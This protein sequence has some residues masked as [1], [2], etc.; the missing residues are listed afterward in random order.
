MYLFKI[1]TKFK[2]ATLRPPKAQAAPVYFVAVTKA[3]AER[4]AS[5]HLAAHLEVRG[6]TKLGAQLANGIFSG[7][8]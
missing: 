4:W 2:P 1:S 7:A 6:V 3:E 5:E 8:K